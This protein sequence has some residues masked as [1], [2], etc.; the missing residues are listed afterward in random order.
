MVTL[1]GLGLTL[2][3]LTKRD[4]DEWNALRWENVDWLERWE[5]QDPRGSQHLPTFNEFVRRQAREA[6]AKSSFGWVI[7]EGGPMI[8]HVT[9]SHIAWGAMRGGT[10]GYWVSHHRAGEG[11][12]PRAVALVCDFGFQE[13]ELHRIE[14]NIRPENEASLRVVEKL[15]FRY[16]G[17]RQRYIFIDGDWRDHHSFALTAD[18][19]GSLVERLQQ[20]NT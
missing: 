19:A 20:S 9:L 11:I 2:R 7:T 10:I 6:K 8:G 16:E 3:P 15:G 12:T 4:R 13:L 1:T 17:L 18:Q 5:S 14:I